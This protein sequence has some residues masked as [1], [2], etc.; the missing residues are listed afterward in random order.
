[1]LDLLTFLLTTFVLLN[2]AWA[3]SIYSKY[4]D[5]RLTNNGDELINPADWDWICQPTRWCECA[6]LVD[7]IYVQ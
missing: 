2:S 6:V 1:V 7:I 4:D 5:V 3:S